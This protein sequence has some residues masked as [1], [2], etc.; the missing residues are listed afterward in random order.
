MHNQSGIA[1]SRLKQAVNMKTI[2]VLYKDSIHVVTIF[3]INLSK[4]LIQP[5]LGPLY[6]QPPF[7][8]L[9]VITYQSMIEIPH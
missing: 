1:D 7:G 5:T 8:K 9:T 6:L 4:K 3:F 2:I